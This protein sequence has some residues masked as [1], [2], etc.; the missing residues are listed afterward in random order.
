MKCRMCAGTDLYQFLDLG[1]TPLADD[2]RIAGSAGTPVA[3]YPLAVNM[4]ET[5]GLAQ[6]G[7]VVAPE[8]LYQHDYPYESST[9]AA[10]RAHWARFAASVTTKLALPE[11]SLVVDVGSNVGVLL[12]A[13]RDRGMRIQGVDPAPNIV[14][15][16]VASGIPTECAFFDAG[17][18][19]QI[20]ARL[21]HASVITATNVFAHVD[22]L[23][24]FMGAVDSLLDETGLLIVESPYF[25]NLIAYNEYD[26]IYHEHLSY[27]SIRP[28]DR[29]VRGF[30]MEICDV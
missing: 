19:R 5:C 11:R 4:C 21:G 26:T 27:I 28:L 1:V 25:A 7:V 17:A 29:F 10:G 14:D 2:F 20:V 8:A 22:D 30:G 13:F 3:R 18:A 15:L 23:S 6:L 12:S 16:A 24:G 9:T